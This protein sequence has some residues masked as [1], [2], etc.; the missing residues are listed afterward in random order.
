MVQRIHTHVHTMKWQD[1]KWY[2]AENTKV[3]LCNVETII[4]TFDT[5]LF[6]GP[7]PMIWTDSASSLRWMLYHPSRQKSSLNDATFGLSKQAHEPL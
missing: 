7:P 3:K 1:G 5:C 6:F 4:L 2:V